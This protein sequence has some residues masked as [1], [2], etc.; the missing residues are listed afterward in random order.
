M[1]GSVAVSPR[2]T[3]SKTRRVR[4]GAGLAQPGND[5]VAPGRNFLIFSIMPPR[6]SLLSGP[7]A[8][9]ALGM[10]GSSSPGHASDT[11]PIQPRPNILL[12]LVDDMSPDVP[13]ILRAGVVPTPNMERLARRGAYFSAAY[14]AAPGCCP[15]RTAL[16][17]GVE[18]HK[19]GVYYNNHAYRRAPGFIARVKNL[20]EHFRAHGYLAAGYGKVFHQSFQDDDVSSWTPGFVAPFSGAAETA[21][22]KQTLWHRYATEG[23]WVYGPLPDDWDRDDPAKQQQDTQQ[24]NRAIALLGQTHAQPFFLAVGFYRPHVPCIVPQRYFDRFPVEKISLPR[25]YRAGDLEDL[26]KP[27]RWIATHR[28]E[29]RAIVESGQWRAFLQAYYASIAYVD[30]QIGRVLDAL[31]R[32]SHRPNTIVVFASDNGWH[33]GEKNHWSKFALWDLAGRVP[34][35]IAIPG[36][37]PRV[38]DAPVS[39]T[40]LYP[41]LLALAGLP[42]PAHPLDGR[43]LSSLLRGK[44]SE[45]GAPALLT[46]GPGNHALRTRQHYYIRYRDGTEELYDM[47]ADPHQ[48]RNVAAVS[49]FADTKAQLAAQLP[50]GSAEPVEQAL[51]G[52][53]FQDA[54]FGPDQTELPPAKRTWT[55][56]LKP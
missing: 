31:E 1:S 7:L 5:P 8:A 27:A 17:T 14:C 16:L 33:T 11:V 51:E 13:S 4:D 50:A 55:L 45:R 3:D 21:L 30:E 20:P 47:V 2:S 18:P 43:D 10:C 54:A 12:V 53:S 49:A 6:T 19:S 37:A 28:H 39:F 44:T 46:Y 29:H 24:A 48:W 23:S 38:L 56:D 35:A 15:A 34:L 32:S 41:T 42:A 36:A 22:V 52:N 25:G 26:P 40:D 9:L